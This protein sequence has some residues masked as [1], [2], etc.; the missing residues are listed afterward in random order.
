MLF[1]WVLGPIAGIPAGSTVGSSMGHAGAVVGG[2]LGFALGFFVIRLGVRRA[3]AMTMTLDADGVE[4]CNGSAATTYRIPWSAIGSVDRR[5]TAYRGPL[6]PRAPML[7]LSPRP[8]SAWGAVDV[9]ASAGLSRTDRQ[10][11]YDELRARGLDDGSRSP[12]ASVRGS[13]GAR[14]AGKPRYQ[15]RSVF[16]ALPGLYPSPQ[17]SHYMLNPKRASC[18]SSSSSSRSS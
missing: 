8:D 17:P 18:C 14:H 2:L 15:R 12:H 7:R 13:A 1:P 6:A 9:F 11:V 4:F 3:R 10:R 16:S 5:L